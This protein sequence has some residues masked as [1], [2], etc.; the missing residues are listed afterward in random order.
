ME[1]KRLTFD[2]VDRLIGVSWKYS[3]YFWRLG[4][5]PIRSFGRAMPCDCPSRR[6]STASSPFPGN[7]GP[8]LKTETGEIA[9][10]GR[11]EKGLSTDRVHDACEREK[12]P[13][14][15]ADVLGRLLQGFEQL[16]H[17]RPF[18]ARSK[19]EELLHG[20]PAARPRRSRL[21]AGLRRAIRARSSA[22]A[23]RS[24]V[25]P[26]RHGAL[27]LARGILPLVLR[28]ARRP[29]AVPATAHRSLARPPG[30]LMPRTALLLSF[31]C[32]HKRER[33]SPFPRFSPTERSIR[34]TKLRDRGEVL[35]GRVHPRDCEGLARGGRTL[36]AFLHPF[37]ARNQ[38]RIDQSPSR[39]RKVT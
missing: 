30:P 3:R 11:E 27:L 16:V 32:F 7:R 2:D 37:V 10:G 17:G 39:G 19:R 38:N 12:G 20:L 22:R 26:P 28:P 35:I 8:R 31:T 36:L 13:S 18:P 24:L 23:P 1:S 5:P 33:F 25:P 14:I 34:S 4:P 21:A 6:T 9:K 15:L 29:L